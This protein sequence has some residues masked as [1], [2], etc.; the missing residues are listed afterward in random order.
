M[1]GPSDERRD[2]V[3]DVPAG[4]VTGANGGRRASD[5]VRSSSSSGATAP[6]TING[7]QQ[8]VRR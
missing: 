2:A 7:P 8:R 5:G 1:R 6:S 4:R 3:G